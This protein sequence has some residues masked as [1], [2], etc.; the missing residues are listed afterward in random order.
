M[1]KKL[2]LL[3]SISCI[4]LNGCVPVIIAGAGTG[5]AVEHKTIKQH[6]S[7][8]EIEYKI[9]NAIYE[10]KKIYNNNRIIVV[11]YRGEALLTG[12]AVNESY[13]Q[14]VLT[15]AKNMS[16]VIKIYD[17]I[18]IAPTISLKQQ[19]SDTLIT[20]KIKSLILGKVGTGIIVTTE[21]GTVYLMG[22]VTREKSDKAT[23]IARTTSGVKKVVKIFNY[24]QNT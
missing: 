17:Q 1:K 8:N 16:G 23:E 24:I 10:D 14:E 9:S 19:T 13:H 20:T 6:F 11:V 12:Q 4:A 5:I 18:E 22:T 2:L 7:D 21:N 15:I 3:F